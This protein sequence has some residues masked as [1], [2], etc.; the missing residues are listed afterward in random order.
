MKYLI[1]I[2]SLL[3]TQP[4]WS[5]NYTTVP[6]VS[7]GVNTDVCPEF[8]PVLFDVDRES[9][10]TICRVNYSV[11]YDTVCKIPLL[12]FENLVSS[13]IDGSTPRSN[14]FRTDPDLLDSDVST[15]SDYYRS[16]Y[17]RGHMVPAGDMR[18]NTASMAQT[19]YLSNIIPQNPNVNRGAWRYLEDYARSV[20]NRNGEIDTYIITGAVLSDSPDT[21]GNGV[22]IPD[23]MF[24][25]IISGNSIE[26]FVVG[27]D[28]PASTTQVIAYRTTLRTI[29]LMSGYRFF[30]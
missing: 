7:D 28:K 20:V 23:A 24:K 25:V 19:F 2:L 4:A 3:L 1:T 22:C 16:G 11:V 6:N 10:V 15:T 14:S 17:D 26:A 29:M 8:F 5:Q 12:T 21:I 9:V 18:E 30:Y 27:N 13:E